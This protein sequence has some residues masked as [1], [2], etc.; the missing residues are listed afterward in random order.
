MHPYIDCR[1]IYNS[2]DMEVTLV[3]IYRWMD[4]EYIVYAIKKNEI[5]FVIIFMDLEGTLPSERSQ[6]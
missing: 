5:L 3:S 6:T 1:I 4:K 2:Q